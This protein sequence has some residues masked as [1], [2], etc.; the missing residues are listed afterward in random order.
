MAD[1]NTKLKNQVKSLIRKLNDFYPDFKPKR[2]RDPLDE[3]IL[4]ILSQNTNDTNSF[5]GYK[6]LKQKFPTWDKVA[7]AK[8]KDIETAINV[9]GLAP[10]KTQYILSSLEQISL[11]NIHNKRL[12]KGSPYHLNHLKKM[13]LDDALKYLTSLK[14]VGQK[15]AAC[16]L[17]FA[18]NM[19]SFPIDTHVQRILK[20]QDIIPDKMPAEKAHNVMYSITE[21]DDRY[22]L[23]MNLIKYG[24]EV[25][26]SRNPECEKCVIRRTCKYLKNLPVK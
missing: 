13:N 22:R 4:T 3:L 10:T 17:A 26:H 15:T 5:E 20:R 21:P 16:V 11:D 24:R 12:R 9:A 6:R 7:N 23:H 1:S 14:G 2:Q 25:C 8:A 18:C 19:P